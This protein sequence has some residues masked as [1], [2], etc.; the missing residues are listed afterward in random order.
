VDRVEGATE[1]AEPL[2]VPDHAQSVRSG[3]H[4]DGS[5]KPA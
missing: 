1:D 3:L 4:L 5:V 2:E